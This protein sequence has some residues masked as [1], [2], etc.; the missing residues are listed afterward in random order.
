MLISIFDIRGIVHL[1]SAPEDT[2]VNRTL[3]VEVLRRLI[4][5]MRGERGELWIDRSVS[6][7][8]D[9]APSEVQARRIVER[10]L[11]EP[12]AA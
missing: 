5:A 10:P 11:S 9:K 3:F 8:H 12:S 6:L 4:G 1:E 7:Q 2:A